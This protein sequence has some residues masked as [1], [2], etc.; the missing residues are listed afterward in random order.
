MKRECI[1]II[2][3]IICSL[4]L[5][6]SGVQ[7][8]TSNAPIPQPLDMEPYEY[9][10]YDEMTTLLQDLAQNNSEFMH[11]ESLGTTFQGRDIWL[12]KFSDHVTDNEAEPEVLLMGAHHG[13]E[14][15][16][17][18]VLIY[19]IK[20]II[21][22]AKMPNTDDD[23]DGLIN[24]DMFDGIDNDGDGI[25]DEDPSEDRVRT[26]LNETEIYVVPMVNPDGV[27][28]E[29]RKNRAPNYGP[30]GTAS[31]ITSY[32]VDLNRNYGY[33][34]FFPNIFPDQ[35]N[36]EWLEDDHSWTYR[37]E[38]PFCEN[39]TQAI[40]TFVE[41]HD[42]QISLSYH[43]YGEW[44]VFPWMHTSRWTPHELLF[45]S[46]GYNISQIN[47]YE[48]RIYGQYGEREYLF[49]RFCGTPG[50]SENWLYGEQGIIAYTIELC[51]RRPEKNPTEVL[52][53][54]WKHV[55]VNLYVCQRSQTVEQEKLEM[56]RFPRLYSFFDFI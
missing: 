15:P 12:V 5:S 18:E 20:Y 50:S 51:K 27:E 49:P 22:K 29:W 34:W 11:L 56:V 32:G 9:Y 7:A 14:K 21:E 47:K 52:N 24:E 46:I 35:Y 42:I 53:A 45:R 43:D 2:V 4:F 40:K 26:I 55:G 10:T 6:I 44:M 3:L 38:K 39:E 1:A 33:R 19:F 36:L 16:S 23:G 54:C 8:I 48:L 31:Y 13:D 17:F 28:F 25:V 41:A 37:G 30:D